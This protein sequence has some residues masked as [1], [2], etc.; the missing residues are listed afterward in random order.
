MQLQSVF[1]VQ[2]HRMYICVL[3]KRKSRVFFCCGGIAALKETGDNFKWHTLH[4][5]RSYSQKSRHGHAAFVGSGA[6]YYQPLI[7]LQKTGLF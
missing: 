2:N 6:G 1:N 4:P 5:Q 7:A 3:E